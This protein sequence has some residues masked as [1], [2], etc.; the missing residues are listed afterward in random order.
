VQKLIG[1]RKNNRALF[2]GSYAE[3]WRK[4]AGAANLYA[5]FRGSGKNRIVVVINNGAQGS[6]P[7]TMQVQNNHG[8]PAADRA[9]LVD[10][11][12]L[13]DLLGSGAPKAVAVAKGTLFVDLPPKTM[14]IYRVP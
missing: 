6:G 2:E 10:G 12:T 11:T 4:N 1:I 5:F 3:M 13:T 14:G 8:I 9:V 7:V